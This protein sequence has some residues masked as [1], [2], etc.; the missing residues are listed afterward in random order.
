MVGVA[1]VPL[2]PTPFR[3]LPRSTSPFGKFP[4][5]SYWWVLLFHGPTKGMFLGPQPMCG[6]LTKPLAQE[7]KPQNVTEGVWLLNG[8]R[9][10]GGKIYP[11][12]ASWNG[13]QTWQL[14]SLPEWTRQKS[15]N[16]ILPLNWS[17]PPKKKGGTQEVSHST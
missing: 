7:P 14:F 5:S 17:S 15:Q 4:I 12:L 8:V 6:H 9:K 11:C 10:N 1:L 16:F 3:N 13:S 2:N